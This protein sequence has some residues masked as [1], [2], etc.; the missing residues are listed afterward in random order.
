MTVDVKICG[1]SDSA[2]LDVAIKEGA[3]YVGFVFF[4]KS[5]RNIT[6]DLVERLLV[7]L[8]KTV[9]AVALVVDPSEELVYIIKSIPAIS[10]IQLHG[11]ED[12]QRVSE[13]RKRT[14][15]RII[16][17]IKVANPRDLEIVE[18]YTSV[19]DMILFDAK[20]P[21]DMIGALPGGN[22]VSFDWEI[23]SGRDWKIPWMLSGGLDSQNVGTAIRVSAAPAVDV[24]SGVE[25][26]PGIKDGGRITEFLRA[27]Q[28]AGVS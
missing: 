18:S 2:G 10:F 25:C 19:A 14:G 9:K 17:A 16:K 8:P 11:A 6:P 26:A 21:T 28:S 4:P 15:K 24:S 20:T 22:A 3:K 12:P 13:I 7:N 23:L 5:P 27:V 1:I